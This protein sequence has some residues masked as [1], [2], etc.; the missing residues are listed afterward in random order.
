M[1]HYLNNSAGYLCQ[2]KQ[3]GR[4]LSCQIEAYDRYPELALL[5]AERDPFRCGFKSPFQG[6]ENR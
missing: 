2:N 3:I 4:W 5:L 6:L 1:L